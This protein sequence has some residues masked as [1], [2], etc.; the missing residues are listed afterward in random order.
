MSHRV[1][2]R[3]G[4]ALAAI[5]T[6][7]A[8]TQAGTAQAAFTS[9]I[10]GPAVQ[11]DGTDVAETLVVGVDAGE[12]THNLADPGFASNK[13]WD[14][15]VD[16]IQPLPANAS[17][18]MTV[19]SLGGDDVIDLRGAAT[20]LLSATLNG[21]AGEDQ[22]FGSGG[23]DVLSGDAGEDLLVGGPGA[24]T[25]SGGA[26]NDVLVWNN[27]DGSDVM[28]GGEGNDEVV[29]N[30]AVAGEAFSIV[31]QGGRVKLDRTA[32]AAFSL[33]IGTVERA[34]VNAGIGADTITAGAGL[35][36][37]ILLALD[38]GPGADAITGGDG[39]DLLLGGEGVDQLAGGAGDDRVV[40]NRGNDAM[41][42]GDGDDTLVWNNGD[43]SDTADG[44]GG[45]DTV[46]VNGAAVAGD[47]F[48]VSAAAGG[49]SRFE[50][51][52]LGPFAID[53]EA[54]ALEVNGLGGGDSLTVTAAATL[55]V[56]A[57]GG[58]G[59]DTLSG[60]DGE[61]TLR[62]GSGVDT[63]TGGGGQDTLDGGA[64][65]D[66]IA[67]RDGIGDLVRCGLGSDRATLDAAAVDQWS[68]CE[69]LD[70]SP[71]AGPLTPPRQG[72]IQL[73][74]AR[75]TLANNRVSIPV[76][77]PAVATAGCKGEIT[78]ETARALRL[79][80]VRVSVRLGSAGYNLRAGANGSVRVRLPAAARLLLPRSGR[81]L[82]A[83]ALIRNRNGVFQTRRLAIAVPRR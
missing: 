71:P 23:A 17:V 19:A 67:A 7:A 31:A 62:G 6:A 20:S 21:G 40:G 41:A 56:E 2:I 46:E 79:G 16:G 80:P 59:D 76:R 54:E 58:N 82:Q 64:G 45:S 39:P 44:G 25:A 15:T 10:T 65:D 12:L 78:L 3:R 8:L 37:L 35:E 5:A 29:V 27:G 69:A 4:A 36:P 83:R 66:I 34:T 55:A 32:P 26:G 42:G 73:R 33:D 50:R 60:G 9:A 68:A 11:L 53:L 48:V 61:D 52:N 22:M 43:G 77:C 63:L 1:R 13:D 18:A 24:D 49:R 47:V 51:T 81:T 14:T 30:G 74:A 38:G 75:V 72:A 28:E 70:Q 57:N